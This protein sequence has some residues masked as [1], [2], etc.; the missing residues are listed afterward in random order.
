MKLETLAGALNEVQRH[1]RLLASR[2]PRLFAQIYLASWLEQPSCRMHEEIFARLDT[3][4]TQ[5][6]QYI[7]IAAP[8]GHAKSAIVTVAYVLWSLLYDHEKLILVISGTSDLAAKQLQHVKVELE[9]NPLILQDFPEL[10]RPKKAPPWRKDAI[11]V[12]SGSPESEGCMLLSYAAHQGVRGVRFGKHR[13]SL[14]IVDD[15]EEK[16]HVI[17]EDQRLKLTHWFKSSL[18]RAGAPDA[19]VIVVGTILHPESLL[20]DLMS[21]DTSGW[22]KMLYKAVNRFS[23]RADLWDQWKRIQANQIDFAQLRGE[24]GANAF[25]EQ[26]KT[27]MLAD[28][29]VLWPERYDYR[30]LMEIRL[31]EGEASFQ[32]EMQNQ[33]LDPEQCIF[34]T[35]DLQYWDD[36]YADVK[37]LLDAHYHNG[38]FYG[39]CDPSLGADPTRGD[40][41]AIIVLFVPRDSETKYIIVADLVRQKP[42]E[43][44][45]II[46]GHGR[47]YKMSRF[48]IETNQFQKLML[49]NLKERAEQQ[50]LDLNLWK[51]DS[52]T[53]KQQRIAG[54]Q[55]QIVQGKVIFC[56]RH[57]LLLEQ[58]YRFPAGKH[59]DGPDALEMAV[60]AALKG[61]RI[62][63]V[64]KLRGL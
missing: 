42:D 38:D 7:A 2:S 47:R 25:F 13:P 15:L 50:H 54:L 34:A 12:P 62:C 40:Y 4:H 17:S 22:T 36:K 19:N 20:A 39:A 6:K 56:R 16:T 49:D 5:R 55:P 59:D 10:Q 35:A 53:N 27:D 23:P 33:P 64:F 29:A 60:A 61:P 32:S 24:K 28:T 11:Y 14:I 31:R 44:C 21:E 52:R 3:L 57:K 9:T 18:L 48:A 46:L 1:R 45:S 63:G 41:G 37:A 8:R 26:H 58:L 51:I 30:A 43:L